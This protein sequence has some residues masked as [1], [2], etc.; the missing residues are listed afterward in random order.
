ME[1]VAGVMS[2]DGSNSEPSTQGRNV[3]VYVRVPYDSEIAACKVR[4]AGL[5]EILSYR[6]IEGA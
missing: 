5:P 3:L 6:L 4:D 2:L 1:G